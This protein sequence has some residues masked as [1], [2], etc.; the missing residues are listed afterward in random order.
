[1]K[2]AGVI[3]E[4][5]PFHNGHKY[6]LEQS[7]ALSGADY[8]VA[9][10]SGDFVQRG[11]PAVIDKYARTKMAL[12]NGA[13]L[14]I[15]L[16]SVYATG[17]AEFFAMGAVSLLDKLG[18]V[19]SLCFGSECGDLKTL[20]QTASVLLKEPEEYRAAL[21]QGLKSGLS[22]PKARSL[23]LQGCLPDSASVD[24]AIISPNNILGTEYIKA[25]LKRKSSITPLTFSRKGNSY[26]DI[27]LNK[28][29]SIDL[30]SNP[31]PLSSA[32]AIRSSIAASGDLSEVEMHVPESV[33]RLLKTAYGKSFPINSEDFFLLLKYR[34]LSESEKGF[35]H[36]QDM[37][38]A[39]SDKIR[40]NLYC[41]ESFEQLCGLLKSKD[42]TYSRI[43]RCLLHI[44]LGM[45]NSKLEEYIGEDYIFYARIL[46]FRRE[47]DK[48][49]GTLKANASIPL[50]SKLADASSYL[51][52]SGVH[53]LENDMRAAHIYDS[54]ICR[55]FQVPFIN[56]YSRQIIIL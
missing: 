5:N 53:M 55:K 34:L 7:R 4:Y 29:L 30:D 39:L 18:A 35:S 16:P 19:D 50:I 38:P 14:V 37:T 33:S 21:Q 8:I 12:L 47:S 56:E 17:S 9:V 6:H 36:Y 45:T 22:F 2:I 1:M 23:A 40:K 3:A 28:N 32:S 48:L 49:L 43:S 10:I 41:C 26:H 20:A 51:T 27:S 44:L 11:A 54:V 31:Y 52:A 46:G 25:L 42:V 15:E 24:N 13:D